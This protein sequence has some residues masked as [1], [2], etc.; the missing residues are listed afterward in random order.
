[1]EPL[2]D[3]YYFKNP[4]KFVIISAVDDSMTYFD[5]IEGKSYSFLISFA[6]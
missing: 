1:L 6:I 4:F 5:S 3:K 2:L